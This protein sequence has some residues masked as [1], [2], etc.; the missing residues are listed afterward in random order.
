MNRKLKGEFWAQQEQFETTT[1]P[2][3]EVK[4]RERLTT[5]ST[6]I[7]AI[8]LRRKCGHRLELDNAGHIGQC[9]T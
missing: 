4:A 7:M 2:A 9:Q 3:D 1:K 8:L 5:T 6:E